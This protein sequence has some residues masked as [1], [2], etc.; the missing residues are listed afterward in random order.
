M[1]FK[2]VSELGEGGSVCATELQPSYNRVTTELQPSSKRAAL[3]KLRLALY[4][5]TMEADDDANGRHIR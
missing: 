4:P 2:K 5:C 1:A 3:S